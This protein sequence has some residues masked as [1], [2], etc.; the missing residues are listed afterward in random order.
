MASQFRIQPGFF[1]N[2]DGTEAKTCD[3][4]RH[5]ACGVALV[6]P[7]EA[8]PWVRQAVSI[9]QDELGL[10]ILGKCPIASEH[11]E[12]LDVPATTDRDAPVLLSCCFHQLGQKKMFFKR[13][14][15][16][17][18]DVQASVVLSVTA[19]QDEIDDHLWSNIMH[20]PVRAIFDIMKASG[21][22]IETKT[23]PWGRSWRN[24]SGKCIAE[25]ASS[26]QFHLRT[27]SVSIQ[28]L[29]KCSGQKGIYL[30]AKTEDKKADPRFQVLWMDMPL[31]ELRVAAAS[32]KSS[33]GLVKVVKGSGTKNSRGIRFRM[34]D[35]AEA[36]K[37]LKPSSNAPTP[38]QVKFTARLAPTPVGATFDTIKELIEHKQWKA[39][40]LKSLGADTWLIGFSEKVNESWI[41][42][43]NKLILITWD[44]PR[45]QEVV[46]PVLAGRFTLPM[47]PKLSPKTGDEDPWAKWIQ[48]RNAEGPQSTSSAVAPVTRACQGP[49]EE[50]FT[51]QDAKI[52]EMKNTMADI[53]K[54]LDVAEQGKAE[55]KKEVDGQFAEVRQ[56]VKTQVQDLTDHFDKTLDRAMRRQDSQ[57]ET[58]FSEL[59]ALIL[60]RPL[61][62]KKA[63][64]GPKPADDDQDETL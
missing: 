51:A 30:S 41:S 45:K 47:V 44:E 5:G 20:S 43:M 28:D 53:T 3:H 33:L 11:C 2:E 18:V 52:D 56:Q 17:P 34:E 24:G 1:H 16:I 31:N 38:V 14:E 36:A 57:L 23:P 60:N 40:P 19:F 4:I 8:V 22:P 12:R 50:R 10:L 59:K 27:A 61:P 21:C 48:N 32:H 64:M 49:I 54:R 39:R 13:P 42:W 9:T 7:E 26:I 62:A 55:F 58:S 25:L 29:L 15:D 37:Q 35:L 63:K 6:D 46:R